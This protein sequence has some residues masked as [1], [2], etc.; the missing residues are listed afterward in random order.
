LQTYSNTLV[1]RN[2]TAAAAC[3]SGLYMPAGQCPGTTY[4]DAVCVVCSSLACPA[5]SYQRACSL[6]N[7]TACVPYTQCRANQTLRNRG[8]ASD[9]VCQACT[10]CSA[11]GLKTA[12]NCSQYQDSWCSGA[13]CSGA[14]PCQNLADRNLFCS[15]DG[16]G[17]QQAA[18]ATPGVCGLC[19]DGYSSDGVYCY[20]C[21]HG[22]TCSRTG[23]ALCAG[24]VA[25]GYEP[26]CFGQYAQP[27]GAACPVAPDPTRIVTHSTFVQPNGNC[28]PYFACA[29][30]YFKHFS[31]VGQVF[32]D[33]CDVTLLPANFSWFSQGLSVNDPRSCT[34]DCIGRASWPDGGCAAQFS[35][36]YIPDNAQG[37]YDDGTGVLQACPNGMTS[38]ARKAVSA[39][40]CVACSAPPGTVGD[41]CE[42]WTCPLGVSKIGDW[43]FDPAQCP[44]NPAGLVGY[45]Y[46]P[47]SGDCLATPL[48]WQPAGYLKAQ[49]AQGLSANASLARVNFS[50]PANVVLAIQASGWP[51][52]TFNSTPY[53]QSRRHSLVV[54][55]SQLVALPGQPCSAVALTVQGRRYVAIA[56]C[57]ASFISFLDLTL[58]SPVPRLLIGSNASGYQE[59]FRDEALFGSILYLAVEGH[60]ASPSPAIYVS[61]VL[62]CA[63]RIVTI[64][65]YPGDLLT[66]SYWVYGASA[67]TC[68][69]LA[70]ALLG[71]GRL[72]AVMNQSYFLFPASDG[73]YQLDSGTRSVVSV[74]PLAS[75]PAGLPALSSLAAVSLSPDGTQLNLTF[76]SVTAVL[77]SVAAQC[78][79]GFTSVIGG[80]CTIRCTTSTNY[81]DP[82]TGLC[83][84]CFTRSCLV[85]EGTVQCTPN[86]PQACVACPALQPYLGLYPLIYNQPGSCASTNTLYVTFCP[87]GKY[88]ST[89]L[90][91]NFT[92]CLDC[93]RL[94]TTP[95]DGATSAE[96]CRCFDGT[97]RTASG[98][99]AVG[100]IYPLP[101]LS[102]CPFGTYQRGGLEVCTSCRVD[103]FPSCQVGFYPTTNNT[104]APCTLPFNAVFT[105]QG[106]SVN[107]PLSCEFVCLPGFYPLS[108]TSVI[109]QCQPCTNQPLVAGTAAAY[110]AVTNGQEDSPAGCVWACYFPYKIYNGQ[111]VPCAPTDPLRLGPSCAFPGLTLNSSAGP[112]AHATLGNLTYRLVT[113]NASGYIQFSQ[114]TTVDLLLVGGGGAG[115]AVPSGRG[116]GGGGGAGQ[117]LLA[118]GVKLL[119]NVSY[120]ITVGAG[121][122]WT[123]GAG[124]AAQS[125]TIAG[126]RALYGGNGGGGYDNSGSGGSVGA[127]GG[128]TGSSGSNATTAGATG[129]AGYPG[130]GTTGALMA[131]GGGGAGCAGGTSQAC[132]SGAINGGNG[133]RSGAGGCGR[134]MWANSSSTL[135]F[136]GVN[137]SIAGGGGGGSSWP[138]CPAGAA[139]DAA[140]AGGGLPA[141]PNTGAGGGGAS[142]QSAS[143]PFTPGGAGGSGVVVVRY[144]DETCVCGG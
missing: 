83:L 71:A 11:Y 18:L 20:E 17:T 43:C 97:T 120:A 111:C 39:A 133:D 51:A 141:L 4:S 99:C 129:T 60:G 8:V 1:C 91:R 115:G 143:N 73:V 19:P 78:P 117:V 57:N 27:T 30:G 29:P 101:T 34:I 37:E 77:T 114:N 67:G 139:G 92:V 98:S 26:W 25:I 136:A 124:T 110:Y 84:P 109:F 125:S 104:C 22:T 52:L 69:T 106:V 59:G 21:P 118:Y 81:V 58:A 85:G 80:A 131:G 16:L 137:K 72:F 40:D 121:G 35:A 38:A 123:S 75:A 31:T 122:A 9:G 112:G 2:C 54:G 61:D 49:S 3:V 5:G 87:Q 23:Q 86:S 47:I 33:P 44:I 79:S 90:Y 135:F 28:A 55:Q 48:P 96:Q 100:Q 93:P 13:A 41:P 95:T 74:L 82:R 113:F 103:P 94:S 65:T 63:L 132:A 56:F 14:S 46:D 10:N 128:G 42:A 66:R 108:N 116:A 140:G 24:E 45:S 64:P 102:R 12:G 134:V 50:L 142:S 6:N 89:T 138:L 127:S 130:G 7:N 119:A 32:C 70:G 105:S 15:W 144:V 76:P 107:A 88:L 36:Y 53:G 68:K 62:N 126:L